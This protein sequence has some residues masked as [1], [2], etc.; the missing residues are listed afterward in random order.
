MLIEYGNTV[1]GPNWELKEHSPTGYT[2]IYYVCNGDVKYESEDEVCHLQPGYLYALPT[3]TPYHVW[4]NKSVSFCCTYMHVGL[5]S[6]HI[7]RLIA[8]KVKQDTCLFYY[9]RTIQKAIDE[10]RIELL[11]RMGDEAV[12]F[13]RHMEQFSEAS[14]MFNRV[15]SYII[16]H[17][18]EELN[19]NELSQLFSYHPNYFISRFRQE[20]GYTPYQLLIRMRMQYAVVLL[21]RGM[22]NKELCYACGYADSST[23][24]RAFKNHYGVSPQRYRQGYRRP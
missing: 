18:S 22:G 6:G 4:K 15:Q 11:E 16:R 21:N 7:N 3:T 2:R 8:L 19:I 14:E 17:I 23:F 20:V 24:T 13:F 1:V 5:V 12:S 9:V 10:E